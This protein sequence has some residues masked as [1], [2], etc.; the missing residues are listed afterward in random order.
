M[1]AYETIKPII[2]NAQAMYQ[3][4]DIAFIC[5][6]PNNTKNVKMIENTVTN[7]FI[8]FAFFKSNVFLTT[9]VTILTMTTNTA[10]I[11]II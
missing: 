2:I 1:A 7:M 10:T 9:S 3:V 8:T 5:K 11:I 4:S 6:Y